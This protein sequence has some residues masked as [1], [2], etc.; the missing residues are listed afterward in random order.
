MNRQYDNSRFLGIRI[1]PSLRGCRAIVVFVTVIHS[2]LPRKRENRLRHCERRKDSNVIILHPC[3]RDTGKFAAPGPNIMSPEG[4]K[5]PPEG[6]RAAGSRPEGG[7]FRPEGD[8]MWPV[9]G[10]FSSSPRAGVQNW[11]YH[12]GR[13]NNF[14]KSF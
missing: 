2:A 11:Q 8:I 5:L 3:L 12:Y 13:A 14:L 9:G 1:S 7:N 6:H 10:K 4:Q